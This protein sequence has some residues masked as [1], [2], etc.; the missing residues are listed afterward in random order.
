MHT[1]EFESLDQ[2]YPEILKKII[3]EG[4]KVSP[5]GLDTLEIMPAVITIKN[6]RKRVIGHPDRKLNYGF[7]A[8]ELLWILQGRNDLD[9]ILN[10]NS[11]YANFS[12][13]GAALN[14]AYGQRIFR[15][16]GLYDVI[17]DSYVDD[18]GAT[19]PSFS[20]EH[21]VVNQ[22]EKAFD[23]LKEDP[24]TRQAII[25]IYNPVQDTGDTKDKPC[26]NTIQFTIRQGKL[27]M[28]VFMRSNDAWLGLPYDAFNFMTMQEVM[29][30]RLGVELGKY[31]HFV[32]SL[33]LYDEHLEDAKKLVKT[34]YKSI[35]DEC[36]IQDARLAPD[37]LDAEMA[38]VYN[39][40]ATTR[41]MA[42]L[43]QL[44]AVEKLLYSS[45]NVYWR[46]IAAVIAVYNF[47]KAKRTE[48]EVN[49][50]RNYIGNEFQGLL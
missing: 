16:E 10:Y 9:S 29:A 3:K 23:L 30:G 34:K 15:W 40:E 28:T 2:A 31:T 38:V 12:D 41:T 14:G 20:L 19:H 27:N 43:I 26:T 4:Y 1:F 50:L 39:V 5:R 49:V 8:G 21:I 22:F 6:P 25:S 18:D 37:V 7:M 48:E 35:Y 44:E 24:L 45:K 42:G 36:D 33:H 13:D 46:S 17:D 47:K 32:D 11:K